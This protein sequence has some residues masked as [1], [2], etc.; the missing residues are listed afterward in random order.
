[1]FAEVPC[2]GGANPPQIFTITNKSAESIDWSS[3]VGPSPAFFTLEPSS[4]RLAPGAI[5]AITV[6]S[7]SV[8]AKSVSFTDLNALKRTLSIVGDPCGTLTLSVEQPLSGAFFDWS[9]LMLDF[10]SVPLGS[11]K[12]LLVSVYNGSSLNSDNAA[13]VPKM[14]GATANWARLWHVTFTPTAVGPQS[15]AMTW[16]SSRPY[17]TPN[18][19]IAQGIGTSDNP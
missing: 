2:G 9:P 6:T 15:A 5:A 11:S 13:F 17:C 7:P 8:P 10:G 16:F 14:D 12:E 19:F 4:G 18:T 3:S 1:M